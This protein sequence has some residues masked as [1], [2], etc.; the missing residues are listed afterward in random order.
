MF[1]SD[2]F[3]RRW[4][5]LALA[6]VL[7]AAA[8]VKAGEITASLDQR[9]YADYVVDS[10]NL[11]GKNSVMNLLGPSAYP[12]FNQGA[13][14]TSLGTG[15]VTVDMG[16]G[17]EIVDGPG[18]DLRVYEVDESF[19]RGVMF[20]PEQ[21]VVYVSADGL[22]WKKA[23][24]GEGVTDFD[25]A[26]TGLKEARYVK[27]KSRG[28]STFDRHRHDSPGP[29]IEAI[30]ALHMKARVPVAAAEVD[31]GGEGGETAVLPGP[32][33]V[34][35][36]RPPSAAVPGV[37]PPR[38]SAEVTAK[39]PPQPPADQTPPQIVIT[40]PE[41]GGAER[42]VQR[43][44]SVTIAGRA[45]DESGIVYVRINGREAA[46]DAA[47]NFSLDVF[48]SVGE[49]KF[50]VE[51]M[52]RLANVE[53]KSVLLVRPAVKPQAPAPVPSRVAVKSRALLVGIN[54][55]DH[56]PDL[57]NPLTDVKA[58]ATELE[59][60]YGFEVQTLTNPSKRAILK[61]IRRLAEKKYGPNEELLIWFSGHGH[62]DDLSKIGYITGQDSRPPAEDP[63]FES[64]IDYP[65]LMQTLANV[66]CPH[67][68]LVVDAC[69]AGTLDLQLA[70][71][72]D[73][74]ADIPRDEYITRKLKYKT[75]LYL[76]SGGKKYVPDGRPGQHSPFTRK[77]LEALRSY[78]G[79]DGV[80][81]FE[82]IVSL[83][84]D[85][86]KPQPRYNEFLGNEPGSSFIFV[87]R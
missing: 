64:F 71:R 72:G 69:F 73:M 11:P 34:P 42:V 31:S 57:L 52:D 65:K 32:P 61:A 80:L 13:A 10:G 33:A 45:K 87:A 49:N 36:A 78:G 44:A 24:Y 3:G 26:K 60:S 2:L 9:A 58:V 55:Y 1:W 82:E 17:E 30:E 37:K 27:I 67:I 41:T 15:W 14:F 53:K 59:Q 50:T 4:L 19:A 43:A 86:V 16:R 51:A 40:S 46:L 39:L 81:S 54:T 8:G 70:M 7:L 20:M 22:D 21:Y 25:L 47:G 84:M 38:P 23:G 56:L 62:F 6:F 74:Y 18:P 83:Y 29:E 77:F 35:A 76:T 12:N 28:I 66:P 79:R 48:L 75:R 5:A 68:L 63:I 85:K